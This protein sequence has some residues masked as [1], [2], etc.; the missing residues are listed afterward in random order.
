MISKEVTRSS[1][2]NEFGRLVVGERLTETQ[3]P[4]AATELEVAGL[5]RHLGRSSPH[6][7]GSLWKTTKRWPMVVRTRFLLS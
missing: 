2:V 1:L 7:P 4:D 3:F 6:D 5:E